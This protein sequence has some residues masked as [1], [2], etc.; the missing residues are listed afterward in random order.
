MSGAR[1]DPSKDRD[2]WNALSHWDYHI[3]GIKKKHVRR[4][5]NVS[6]KGILSTW[7]NICKSRPHYFVIDTMYRLTILS[8]F[9]ECRHLQESKQ[10]SYMEQSRPRE[11]NSLSAVT[12][13]HR[14]LWKTKATPCLKQRLRRIL[15]ILNS[16]IAIIH[17]WIISQILCIL[18]A[19]KSVCFI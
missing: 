1:W 4:W 14:L 13:I 10:T 7:I 2:L 12:E 16:T 8:V 5:Q 11:A 3:S 19:K 15:L 17:T 6:G 9:R 18:V